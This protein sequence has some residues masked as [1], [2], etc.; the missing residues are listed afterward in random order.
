[1]EIFEG[2]DFLLCGHKDKLDSGIAVVVTDDGSDGHVVGTLA[3]AT[4][5]IDPGD[6]DA[7]EAGNHFDFPFI[8]ALNRN[9]NFFPFV[10]SFHS[11]T[12]DLPSALTPLGEFPHRC[13]AFDT[14]GIGFAYLTLGDEDV[15]ATKAQV[16]LTVTVIATEK[17]SHKLTWIPT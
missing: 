8:I 9:G 12:P 3:K 5:V 2:S 7:L 17:A 16:P 1:M 11:W 14:N 6:L 13:C 15:D 4:L 10:A